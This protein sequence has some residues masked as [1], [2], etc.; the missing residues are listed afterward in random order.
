M[1]GKRKI[2]I[3]LRREGI[4]VPVLAIERILARLVARGSVVAVQRLG[5]R[6]CAS[7]ICFNTKEYARRLPKGRKSKTRGKLVRVDRFFVNIR[8]NKPINHRHTVSD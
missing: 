7:R 6:P 3:L 1:R 5:R 4:D 2:A 8:P